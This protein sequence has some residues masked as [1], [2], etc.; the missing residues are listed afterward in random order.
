LVR[1]RQIRDGAGLHITPRPTLS[2]REAPADGAKRIAA[3]T[4]MAQGG[5]VSPAQLRIP[6]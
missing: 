6:I 4:E 3:E 1:L 5:E 2:C